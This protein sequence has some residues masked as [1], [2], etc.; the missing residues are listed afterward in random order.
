MSI[1][2]TTLSL[3]DEFGNNVTDFLRSN[4]GDKLKIT[5]DI[6]IIT[7]AKSSSSVNM[8]L[9]YSGGGTIGTGWVNDPSAQF[10]D[11]RVGDIVTRADWSTDTD[12]D[13]GIVVIDKI[14]DSLIQFNTNFGYGFDV[15]TS[16]SIFNLTTAISAVRMNYN[17]I[18]NN[19]ST[20]YASKIDG[21]IQELLSTGLSATY[22]QT[23]GVLIVGQQY[24]ISDFNAGDNFT[25]VGG[26]NV[27]G[28][29]F[30]ATGTT[31]T[32]YSNGSTLNRVF[33]FEF[34]GAK[35]Y[36]IGSAKIVCMG[37]NTTTIYG[38]KFKII[39]DTFVTPFFLSDQWSDLVQNINASYYQN[40]EC[41]RYIFKLEA[42]YNF[43]DP[44]RILTYENV[45][46]I[47][48]NNEGNSGG[49][50]ENFNSDLTNY[51]IESVDYTDNASNSVTEIPLTTNETNFSIVIKN[52]IDTPFSNNNTK[53]TLNFIRAP[54]DS[55][56]YQGNSKTIAENFCFDRLLNTIGS[57]AV[58]GDTF[59][60]NYQVFKDVSAT[61]DS[62][63]Q[64]T[65]TGKIAF[66]AN[67]VSEIS[68]SNEFR[69]L[70]FASTQDHTKVSNNSDR[71]CLLVDINTFFVDTS[72]LTMISIDNKFIS[73]VQ[74]DFDTDGTTNIF[75]AHVEDEIVA[76][77]RFYIDSN[78]RETDDIV[79]TSI[80]SE[81]VC[82]NDT[83]EEEF[84]LDRYS[85]NMANV[86]PSGDITTPNFQFINLTIP[87]VFNIPTTEIRKNIEVKRRTD[88]DAG[89]LVYFDVVFPF[90]VRWEY[91]AALAG[92]NSAFFDITKPNNGFNNEW[93]D[94]NQLSNWF[95]Y[96][97][98]T[99]NARKN[100]IPQ[101]YVSR[102]EMPITD[103]LPT[104]ANG[105]IKTYDANNVEL[106]NSAIPR[107]YV[108]GYEDTKIVATFNNLD[109][110]F[111]P[112]DCEVVIGVEV[113]E[114]GGIGG[115]R[116][117]SSKNPRFNPVTW[118]FSATGD[119]LV[120]K[121]NP[122]ST[123]LT[124]TCYIDKSL[125]PT[126]FPIYSISARLYYPPLKGD[127]KIL[128]N[129]T[130]KLTE[131]GIA[132]IVE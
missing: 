77:S 131:D 120:V 7:S 122:T 92:V 15:P 98:V 21:T 5:T 61:F 18:A 105:T 13:T 17:F 110:G 107:R 45:L 42:M 10:K 60:T 28:A 35:P 22:T 81:I 94:Y 73:H 116:S 111:D 128:E 31:P 58:D 48:F 125:L 126:N 84:P 40:A 115:R 124:G 113:F 34:Q 63:S 119:G 108:L 97:K 100:G 114:Q 75:N 52:T 19:E 56:E 37:V 106:Y 55:T 86:L 38:Q 2:I 82:Y 8:V 62:T 71:V 29:I 91:W 103:Y 23:S 121:D 74:D 14:S 41:L 89:G 101:Q 30:T 78:G 79:I 49:F 36:Q 20:N 69:Y 16:L 67:V 72:D 96:Y 99:I 117:L 112:D 64:I 118:L 70:L 24:Y 59:G 88:L 25:N 65:I 6:E 33:D 80:E 102:V 26:T 44:N 129:D 66:D 68:S 127:F 93:F 46:D 9:N 85:I 83:N 11:F 95:C 32:T 3:Q 4:I 43:Q 1:N 90:M 27:T 132:K 12:I 47:N 57:A 109:T 87:R 51:S 53:F 39:H 104:P 50:G 123:T 130:L 54:F 76:R